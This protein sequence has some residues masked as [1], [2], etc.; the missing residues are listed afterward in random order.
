MPVGRVVLQ[1]GDP[2]S[3]ASGQTALITLQTGQ[4]ATLLPEGLLSD[5]ASIQASA[6]YFGSPVNPAWQS[7]A[8]GVT[9]L[10]C[11]ASGNVIATTTTDAP[12]GWS[13]F[14]SLAAGT[15]RV[16]YAPPAGE[17]L[18]SGSLASSSALISV[19]P[20]ESAS[21]TGASI[22]SATESTASQLTFNTGDSD[23]ATLTAQAITSTLGDHLFF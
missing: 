18:L 8:G 9:V 19:N 11:N 5:P 4:S 10:L 20:G 3:L 15:Y 1:S 16:I 12:S 14:G 13:S 23:T 2:A 21:T 7:G 22:V 6:Q 17:Q